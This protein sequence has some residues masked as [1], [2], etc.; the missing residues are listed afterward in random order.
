MRDS[1]GDCDRLRGSDE[2]AGQ[3]RAVLL[4]QRVQAQGYV[5]RRAVR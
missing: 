4:E 2:P 5:D 1:L 3:Q